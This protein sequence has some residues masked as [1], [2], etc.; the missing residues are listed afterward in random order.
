MVCENNLGRQEKELSL[1]KRSDK[2]NLSPKERWGGE[3][4]LDRTLP[5]S[6]EHKGRGEGEVPSDFNLTLKT[7]LVLM[8]L[9]SS[10]GYLKGLTFCPFS[11]FSSP[12]YQC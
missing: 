3:I 11:I 1:N 6:L 9:V 8:G 5:N 4:I 2:Q 12:L 7:V 10:L